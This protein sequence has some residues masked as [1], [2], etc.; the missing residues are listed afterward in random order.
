MEESSHF[1]CVS[2]EKAVQYSGNAYPD[3]DT[4]LDIYKDFLCFAIFFVILA[5]SGWSI[6][7]LLKWF[8]KIWEHLKLE[9][10]RQHCMVMPDCM[11]DGKAAAAAA[12]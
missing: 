7:S 12:F 8:L 11:Y 6:H 1:I 4:G 9:S 10:I 3:K 2:I 5:Q